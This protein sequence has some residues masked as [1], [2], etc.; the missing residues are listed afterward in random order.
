MKIKATGTQFSNC[1][2]LKNTDVNQNI[3]TENKLKA[4]ELADIASEVDLSYMTLNVTAHLRGEVIDMRELEY[5]NTED[6]ATMF[7][8][9]VTEM[10]MS[11]DELPTPEPE[12]EAALGLDGE[13]L[14]KSEEEPMQEL[15]L[16]EAESEDEAVAEGD[17]SKE[18][19]PAKRGRK[20]KNE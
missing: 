14:D 1:Y 9:I 6:L 4:L 20:L 2:V 3:I 15:G 5:F 16:A 17:L 18:V 8:T 13:S 7:E 11:I 10:S 19:K 12:S